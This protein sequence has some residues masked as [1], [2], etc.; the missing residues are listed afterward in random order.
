M[1][2]HQISA[3]R[4]GKKKIIMTKSVRPWNNLSGEI[5]GALLQ[6]SASGLDRNTRKKKCCKYERTR[7][8][9][10]W[11]MSDL[12]LLLVYLEI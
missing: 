11:K 8:L 12:D 6:S 9:L 7:G 2:L 5:V 3:V 4:K 1:K 10:H